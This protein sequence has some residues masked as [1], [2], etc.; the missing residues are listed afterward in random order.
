MI[1]KYMRMTEMS[2]GTFHR[3]SHL[4]PGSTADATTME[5]STTKIIS[6]KKYSAAKPII[7]KTVRTMVPVL[8]AVIFSE[9]RVAIF[10]LYHPVVKIDINFYYRISQMQN[11]F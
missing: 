3:E 4:V 5:R 6:R 11:F 10:K 1:I 2:R 8:I 7:T 9:T